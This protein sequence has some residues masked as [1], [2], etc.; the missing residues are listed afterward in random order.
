MSAILF[1]QGNN[2]LTPRHLSNTRVLDKP[3]DQSVWFQTKFTDQQRQAFA[4]LW[5]DIDTLCH[6]H[7]HKTNV[8][9]PPLPAGA[10]RHLSVVAKGNGARPKGKGL[11]SKGKP[12]I[13]QFS[14]S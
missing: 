2:W 13:F 5:V 1:C 12:R 9:A 7:L 14:D 4:I 6:C 10:R 11:E 8:C 3:V